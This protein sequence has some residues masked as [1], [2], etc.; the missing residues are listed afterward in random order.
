[1][2]GCN[3]QGI[4]GGL[5]RKL[6][7]MGKKTTKQNHSGQ[8]GKKTVR[9]MYSSSDSEKIVWLFDNLDRAGKFSFDVNRSDFQHKE[10]LEKMIAYSSMTWAE[11]KKQTHDGGKSKHHEI[12]AA[13]LSS[14]AVERIRAKKLEEATDSIFS[15]ALQNKLRI[16]GIREGRYFHVLWYD[17][18][19]EA[20]PSKKKHT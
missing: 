5:L 19:H 15:F 4:Y 13:S 1:M 6:V 14:E 20:C 17:P 16:L 18:E 7:I 8:N 12:D 11:I 3:Y 9:Q 10:V 2:S